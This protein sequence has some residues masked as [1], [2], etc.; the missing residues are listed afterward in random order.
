MSIENVKGISSKSFDLDIYPNKPAILVAPNGFG[1]SSI[2]CA[3]NSLNKNRIALNE[4]DQHNRN[5]S[6]EPKITISFDA[7]SFEA[8]GNSNDISSEC[9][10]FVINSPVYAKAISQNMGRFSASSASLDLITH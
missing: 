7:V 10:V 9:D 8:T 6:L 3:F 4:K 5:A 1:K 2:A